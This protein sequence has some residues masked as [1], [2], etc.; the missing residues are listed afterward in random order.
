MYW[1]E[2]AICRYCG[3]QVL[4]CIPYSIY[5]KLK[6]CEVVSLADLIHV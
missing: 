1:F 6:T 2:A 4:I 5:R 3:E